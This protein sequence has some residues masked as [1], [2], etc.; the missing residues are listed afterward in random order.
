VKSFGGADL[1]CGKSYSTCGQPSS[2]RFASVVHGVH[3][4]FLRITPSPSGLEPSFQDI[5]QGRL[6]V[7]VAV[8]PASVGRV[9]KQAGL[10]SRWKWNPSRKGTGFE[11]P[12]Q[13][14]QHWHVDVSDVD[15][16]VGYVLLFVQRAGWMQSFPGALGSAGVD[17][18]S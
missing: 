4:S 17:E 1:P 7:A 18:G 11:Q 9:L 8:S 5:S 10:L 13:P 16:S 2:T 12:R 14:H 15:L 6:V 3:C